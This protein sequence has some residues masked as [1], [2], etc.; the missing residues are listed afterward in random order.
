[1][2]DYTSFKNYKIGRT[3]E[4][5]RSIGYISE[6]FEKTVL[7]HIVGNYAGHNMSPLYLAIHGTMGN[8]KTY[9]TLRICSIHHISVYYIS[10][11]ELS[12]SYESDSIYQI[13]RNLEEA[14][15]SLKRNGDYSVFVIDDFHLSI[16]STEA[17]VGKTVNSQLLTGFLMNLADS[18]LQ[19]KSQR[20]PFILLGNDFNHLY[21]PLTRDGRM[22]FFEWNPSLDEKIKIVDRSMEDLIYSKSYRDELSNLVKQYSHMPISF[23]IELRHDIFKEQLSSYIVSHR[24]YNIRELLGA[25]VHNE[26]LQE[27]AVIEKLKA[28]APKRC[29]NRHSASVTHESREGLS[30]EY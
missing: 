17:G 13:K 9:Q 21:A 12:G 16:A 6:E 11:A 23:F 19:N 15:D 2:P 26:E 8:G 30:N 29:K 24:Q 3:T 20:I 10:A 27:A 18:A 5:D 22:D 25:Y 1:M 4:L 28:L 7:A 14:R